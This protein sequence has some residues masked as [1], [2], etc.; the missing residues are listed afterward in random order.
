MAEVHTTSTTYPSSGKG[1]P[2]RWRVR[3]QVRVDGRAPDRDEAGETPERAGWIP[4]VCMC[5][6]GEVG[7]G[8]G[9]TDVCYEP[10]LKL[11]IQE[12]LLA[13]FSV[14]YDGRALD[15]CGRHH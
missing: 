5:V 2:A 13:G 12:G 7:G 6:R 8:W 3:R 14:R 9:F 15:Q 4:S 1:G 10:H 11:W